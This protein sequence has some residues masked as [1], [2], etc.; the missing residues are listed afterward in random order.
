MNLRYAIRSLARNPGFTSAA[1]LTLALGI[2]ANTAIFSAV[3]AALLRPLPF[4]QPERLVQLWETHPS[5]GQAGVAYPDYVDWRNGAGSFEQIAAYTFQGL[6]KFQL[7]VGGE[8]EEIAGSLVSENLLSTM[9]IQPAIGRNFLAGETQAVLLSDVL[10][11]GR[12]G[13]DPGIIG[14]DVTMNGASFRVIGILPR[15]SFPKWADV[16]APISL[17]PD[18]DKTVR[19]HHLLEVVGRLKPGAS[20]EQGLAEIQAIA[21]RLANDFPATNSTIGAALVPLARQLVGDAR[22]P[23]LVLL[24]VVGLVLLIATANVANLLLARG[25]ARRKEI[26]IRIALGAGRGHLLRQLFIESLALAGAGG[27]LGVLLAAA[28]TP[29]LRVMAAGRIPRAAEIAIDWNVLGFGLVVALIAG[30]LFGLAPSLAATRRVDQNPSLREGGRGS[31]VHAQRGL[32][33][34]L[35]AGQIALAMLVLVCAGLLTRSLARLIGVDP[36]YRTDHLLTAHVTLAPSK[37]NTAAQVQGFYTQLLARIAALPGVQGVAAIDYLPLTSGFNRTRFGVEGAPPPEPGRFPVAQVRGITPNYLELMRIP[38][39]AGRTFTEHDI[40]QGTVIINETLARRFFPGQNAG[41]RILMGVVDTQPTAIP[42][43]GVVADSRDI[44]LNVPADPE[45]Y[46]AGFSNASALVVRTANDPLSLTGALRHEVSAVDPEQPLTAVA[47]MDEI[48]DRSLTGRRFSVL[49]IVLFAALALALAAVGLYGVVSYS[50]AQRTHELGLRMALGANPGDM[51]RMVLGEGLRV[52]LA[53]L[54][55]GA[56]AALLAT[57]LLAS[58]LYGVSQ[59]DPQ[60]FGLAAAALVVIAMAGAYLPA[61]R[62][63]RV[64]P[65]VALREE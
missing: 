22:T 20:P 7:T 10:W 25:A 36:G 6:Q 40:L 30:V 12:F 56:G 19:K 37:Y 11:R 29:W 42:I 27:V 60:A 23:L 35:V 24:A 21:A 1:V 5:F 44:S 31:A 50:V 9:G 17:L 58:E 18:Y 28:A 15:E 46:F 63:M 52:T 2:G 51:L 32:R 8:P 57:R 41:H 33:A 48:A 14:R 13:A 26:A 59:R 4:R 54:A 62:A 43:V 16:L 47:T 39:I 38:L 61:R 49:L 65:V 45:M 55:V 34:M 64:D 53:G 3:D